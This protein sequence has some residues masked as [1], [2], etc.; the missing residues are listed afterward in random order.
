M[1]KDIFGLTPHGFNRKIE[2]EKTKIDK[3]K[4]VFVEVFNQIKYTAEE[5]GWQRLIIFS[6]NSEFFAD[7]PY[8]LR[9][10]VFYFLRRHQNIISRLSDREK[11]HIMDSMKPYL[12]KWT[13]EKE[14]KSLAADA[15]LFRNV[16]K[17]IQEY[18]FD[19]LPNNDL[20]AF[21]D[22]LSV[23]EFLCGKKEQTWIEMSIFNISS[24]SG[25]PIENV[26]FALNTLLKLKLV[27][28]GQV[29]CEQ[30]KG[31]KKLNV[32]VTF[33]ADEY[34]RAAAGEGIDAEQ[35]LTD[36]NAIDEN[37]VF[38][39]VD[40]FY[41]SVDEM[42]RNNFVPKPVDFNFTAQENESV[43]NFYLETKTASE[44]KVPVEKEL[45]KIPEAVLTEKS[46]VINVV[47]P[48]IK[49]LQEILDGIKNCVASFSETAK[50]IYDNETR[51]NEILNDFIQTNSRQRKDYEELY[52]QMV[53]MKKILNK[54]E[55]DKHQF[56]RD[57]Q[58][59]LNMMMGEILT[60]IE[61]FTRIPRHRLGENEIQRCKA[62]IIKITVRAEKK[63]ENLAYM[64]EKKVEVENS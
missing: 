17:D 28:L 59:S 37:F 26:R 3:I 9:S 12:L 43:L 48:E 10:M 56:I 8:A 51:K 2:A 58:N 33:T 34:N 30:R 61:S 39:V 32:K 16:P 41:N 14:K 62:E 29:A 49:G 35:I 20:N 60:E 45:P 22:V 42:S 4:K 24:F 6:E 52:G 53:A 21:I 19:N 54:Q 57:V 1:T 63:I 38:T 31:R 13:S 5:D 25:V 40:Y 55:R 18:I 36:K 44:E 15:I 11:K 7:L 64:P 23:L 27:V 50:S 47:V 46:P